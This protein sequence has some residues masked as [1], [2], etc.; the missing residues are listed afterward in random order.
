LA[1]GAE[2]N[3]ACF[4]GK[5]ALDFAAD[6]RRGDVVDLL[7]NR[8]AAAGGGP[9]PMRGAYLGRPRPGIQPE[10]FAPGVLVTPFEIHGPLA[11][12]PDGANLV[13]AQNARPAT[14]IWMMSLADTLWSRPRIPGFAMIDAEVIDSAP[15]YAP[16]G[17]RLYF[18]SNRPAPGTAGGGP[19]RIWFVERTPEGWSEARPLDAP[20]N[21]Q[22]WSIGGLSMSAGGTLYFMAEED[23]EQHNS[24]IYRARPVNG[25][26]AAAEK[27]GPAVNSGAYELT[28]AI[29]PDES[30]LVFASTRPGGFARGPELYISFR[31]EDGLWSEAVHLDERVNAAGAWQPFISADGELLFYVSR[32]SGAGEYWWV[33]TLLLDEFR[34]GN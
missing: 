21:E 7:K 1:Y 25:R 29:A 30:Y 23:L 8:E 27:L 20:F 2:L 3:P 16:D 22:G 5:T 6:Y 28:P 33:N 31:N 4:N 24:E 18:R 19:S 11:F 13:W 12:S 26:Y 32:Q 14:S 17:R 34:A 10:I 15:C 9:P